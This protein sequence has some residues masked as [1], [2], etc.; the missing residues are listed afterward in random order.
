MP[1]DTIDEFCVELARPAQEQT[2]YVRSLAGL[3]KVEQLKLRLLPLAKAGWGN[4][5][6]QEKLLLFQTF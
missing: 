6:A 2:E 1:I 3:R 4:W 5:P